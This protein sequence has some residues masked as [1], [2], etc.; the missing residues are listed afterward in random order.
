MGHVVEDR[1]RID[2]Q[3]QAT[4]LET[5]GPVVTD[6][7]VRLACDAYDEEVDYNMHG[8]DASSQSVPMKA[9]LEAAL[10]TLGPRGLEHPLKRTDPPRA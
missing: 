2:A 7:M 5:A 1:V 9:A 10:A 4:V 8:P 3:G 6:E